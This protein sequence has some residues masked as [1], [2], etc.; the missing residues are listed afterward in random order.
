MVECRPLRSDG[1]QGMLTMGSRRWTRDLMSVGDFREFARPSANR[2]C[3]V[4]SSS[5]KSGH[6]SL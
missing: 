3:E 1:W 5:A 6:R 4:V 2:Y